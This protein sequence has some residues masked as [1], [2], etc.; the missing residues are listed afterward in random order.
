[1][2]ELNKITQENAELVND[3]SLLGKDV[4]NGTT[5][6]SSE[7]EYFKLDKNFK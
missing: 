6:L 4:V 1:M 2:N 7:L 3:S 5:N